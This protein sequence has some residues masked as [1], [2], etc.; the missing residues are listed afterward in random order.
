[1]EFLP[2]HNQTCNSI[3]FGIPTCIQET[4][5]IMERYPAI[6]R[7]LQIPDSFWD[8]NIRRLPTNPEILTVTHSCLTS[9]LPS[10]MA[11][12][13]SSD[14]LAKQLNTKTHIDPRDATAVAQLLLAHALASNP[15]GIVLFS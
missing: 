2:T 1:M 5:D 12:L 9:R 6:S 10:L 11:Q 4:I 3:T 8:M 13:A 14:F 15:D 7:V